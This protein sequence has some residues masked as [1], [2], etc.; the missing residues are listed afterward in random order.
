[1][2]LLVNRRSV[3]RVERDQA[4]S[5]SENRGL[6]WEAAVRHGMVS[7]RRYDN[8]DATLTLSEWRTESGLDAFLDEMKMAIAANEPHGADTLETVRWNPVELSA[9]EKALLEHHVP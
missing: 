8:A 7:H 1:M 3:N 9:Q 2:I 6:L 4:L 5:G